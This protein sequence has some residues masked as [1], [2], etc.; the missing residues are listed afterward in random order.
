MYACIHAC[1]W[2]PTNATPEIRRK[3]RRCEMMVDRIDEIRAGPRKKA[4][5]P[6]NQ[7]LFAFLAFL[8]FRCV[9]CC[10]HSNVS[11]VQCNA[12]PRL[13]SSRTPTDQPLRKARLRIS[14]L[15]R[16]SLG[17]DH[18]NH[19][20]AWQSNSNSTTRHSNSAHA[21]PRLRCHDLHRCCHIASPFRFCLPNWIDRGV[22]EQSLRRLID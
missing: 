14:L 5:L 19:S 10:C 9:C 1:V 13:A 15:R 3:R 6:T 21:A 7:Q 11:N 17:A 18:S 8:L 22:A 20:T 4:Q 12:M 16:C 2:S